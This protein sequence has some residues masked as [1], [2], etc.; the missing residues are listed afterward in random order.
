MT[1]S[2]PI[3]DD[4]LRHAYEALMAARA[5][6]LDL[7]NVSVETIAALAQGSY[8]APDR[9]LLLD[10]VLAHP[11]TARELHF[12]RQLAASAPTP[13]VVRPFPARWLVA[14]TVLLAVGTLSIWRGFGTGRDEP[15]RGDGAPFALAEPAGGG[16]L[17]RGGRLL[18]RPAPGAQ[19]YR[20]EL[21]DDGGSLVFTAATPDTLATLPDSVRLVPRQAY[22]VRL[23][24]LLRD[25]TEATA[26][27]VTLIAR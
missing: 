12:F 3:T 21:L 20:I 1:M 2:K 26:P 8:R 7:P 22:Q 17:G 4:A 16:A 6:V 24:A 19:S 14:A 11:V 13:T 23:V 27:V 5:N 25:G 15:V 10:R 18:W 9:I